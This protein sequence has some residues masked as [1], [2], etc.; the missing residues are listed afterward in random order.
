MALLA[1]LDE[2]GDHSMGNVDPSS[3]VFC[4]TLALFDS[5]R[6]IEEIVPA[7]TRLKIKYFGHEGI[8]LRSH[9]IRKQRGGFS[10]LR[11]ATVRHEFMDDLNSIMSLDCYELI[12]IAI[13]KDRHAERYTQPANPYDLSIEFALER[14][15]EWVEIKQKTEV[16][17][18]AESRGVRE[19]NNLA[20]EFY[21]VVNNGT[22]F[23][24]RSRFASVE[25]RF[26]CIKKVMN[27]AGHQIADL[28][29][30]AVARQ[31]RDQ[32]KIYPPWTIVYQRI[33]AGK[34]GGK[35]GLKVFP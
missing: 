26:D 16:H 22:S 33:F 32:S 20:K 1:Y 21:R 24:H 18:L 6:Y 5:D 11:D 28:A 34:S 19:D 35:Y 2:S 30:Y 4:L 17:V 27:L 10:I 9:D 31:M 3:P 15:I 14:L 25:F 29:A 12:A 13:R 8:I 7:I 23:A